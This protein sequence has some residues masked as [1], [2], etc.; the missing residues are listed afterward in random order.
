MLY[1]NCIQQRL[2]NLAWMSLGLDFH[3]FHQSTPLLQYMRAYNDSCKPATPQ[4]YLPVLTVR[5]DSQVTIDELQSSANITSVCH[6]GRGI[7]ERRTRL[8]EN[9]EE[10]TALASFY[11][12]HS[13][14]L[15][16][17]PRPWRVIE[18]S[19]RAYWTA[20]HCMVCL[21]RR[22]VGRR[23]M[24]NIILGMNN[25]LSNI[26]L[27]KSKV[28]SKYRIMSSFPICTVPPTH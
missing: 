6:E 25:T 10:Q 20:A 12:C 13:H 11:L 9:R 3:G 2:C 4:I 21:C 7:S 27:K 5:S 17:H 23:A 14:F 16:V 26:M 24:F 15:V 1:S 22:S 8:G 19:M 18:L 28:Y